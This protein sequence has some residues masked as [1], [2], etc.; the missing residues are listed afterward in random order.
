MAGTG[1]VCIAAVV[2]GA[3][4]NAPTPMSARGVG[5]EPG[6]IGVLTFGSNGV[7]YAADPLAT[8]IYALELQSGGAVQGTAAVRG[9]NE[10]I[11][12]LLGTGAT[13]V[14]IRDIAVEPSSRNTLISV[15]RGQGADAKPAILRVDG[16][17]DVTLVPLT[18]VRF[19]AVTLPNPANANVG[20]RNNPRT[21]SVMDMAFVK[22]KLI[23]AGLSNE[24]FASKLWSI[25]YPFANAD[26][27][28]SVEIY[29]GSHG[30]LETR[31]P[32]YS[33]VPYTLGSETHLIAGYLCTPLVKLPLSAL[34]P[35][36]RV[37]GT[38]IAELGAGNRPIDMITYS[39][40][41]QEF[42]LMS[43]TSRGVMK[44][45]TVGFATA[46]PITTRIADK[47]GIGYEAIASLTN[48]QQLD[49]LDA[50][51]AVILVGAAN[52]PLNLQTVVLP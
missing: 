50:T 35:G 51:H 38:T 25:G 9:I 45:P 29:H 26:R 27:G 2:V 49:M 20:G 42:L 22:D 13:E 19:Q 18:D 32:V 28:T 36:A 44:I 33:F 15:M 31:S 14:A 30:A 10:R 52:G 1:A 39:K 41:G 4:F 37:V 6:S 46:A 40:G 23:V 3:T 43:N 24:E 16:A 34:T 8:T 47:A 21:Q 5:P 7:L 17:G 11:A 12:A 48:V